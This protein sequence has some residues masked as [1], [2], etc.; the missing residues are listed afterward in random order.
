[1]NTFVSPDD[2][3]A[4]VFVDLSGYDRLSDRLFHSKRLLAMQ[5]EQPLCTTCTSF[6]KKVGEKILNAFL[7][8]DVCSLSIHSLETMER[9]EKAVDTV[10]HNR[11]CHLEKTSFLFKWICSLQSH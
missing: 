9:I 1:M 7:P 4:K 5:S 10:H 8:S 2:F 11:W 3:A 6:Q